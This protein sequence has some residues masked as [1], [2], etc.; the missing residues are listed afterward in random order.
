MYYLVVWSNYFSVGSHRNSTVERKEYFLTEKPVN[1]EAWQEI[2][3]PNDIP[4]NCVH[5][6]L[7]S[8]KSF[9]YVE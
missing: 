5:F 4:F 1:V 9:E 8:D 7:E 6:I 2:L 3:T